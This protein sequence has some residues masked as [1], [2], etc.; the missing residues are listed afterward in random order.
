M[1]RRL[2]ETPFRYAILVGDVIRG[3]V[4]LGR[5]FG[6]R[7]LRTSYRGTISGD[8]ILGRP[9]GEAPFGETLFIDT[10]WETPFRVAPVG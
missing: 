2:L 7:H 9:F 6:R 1:R 5:H 10:I 8:V 3:D 4:I